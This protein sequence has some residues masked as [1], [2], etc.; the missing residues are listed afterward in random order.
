MVLTQFGNK[1]FG[2][3]A[4]TII[5]VRAILL[6]DR[7]RPQRHHCTHVWIDNRRAQHLMSIWDRTV[8][9]NL[10]QTRRTVNRRGGKIPR[11]IEG[12]YIVPIQERHGFKRLAS[13]ELSKDALE[14]G[15]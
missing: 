14:Q 5:F 3:M 12:Q 2:G 1:A 11:A 7:F 9:V 8:A 13:L 6:Y 10:G 4:F 15:L